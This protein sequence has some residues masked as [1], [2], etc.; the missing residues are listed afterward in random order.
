MTGRLEAPL[1]IVGIV[2][3]VADDD[4]VEEMDAHGVAGCLDTLCQPVVV[5]AGTGLAGG[6]VVAE[7]QHSGIGEDGFLHDDAHVDGRLGNAAVRDA[8]RTDEAVALVH[9]E[10]PRLFYVEVLHE[11]VHIIIDSGG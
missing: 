10:R 8:H 3:P 1:L 6:M 7:G 5:A 2:C 9:Q 11:G 4:M